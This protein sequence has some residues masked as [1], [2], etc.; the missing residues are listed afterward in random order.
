LQRA[1]LAVLLVKH[2]QGLHF[3]RLHLLHIV[4]PFLALLIAKQPSKKMIAKSTVYFMAFPLFVESKGL[5]HCKPFAGF[6]V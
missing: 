3:L 1:C 5:H 4:K 6:T 2:G